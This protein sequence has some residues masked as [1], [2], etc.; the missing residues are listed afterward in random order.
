L[1]NPQPNQFHRTTSKRRQTQLEMFGPCVVGPYNEAAYWIERY[2]GQE[3]YHEYNR[4]HRA[5]S[6]AQTK[7]A[8]SMKSRS[9]GFGEDLGG[10]A[11]D[12][13]TTERKA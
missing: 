4:Q 13:A 9:E 12:S 5:E 11:S 2:G 3:A 8:A 7:P 6:A 10:T 1:L